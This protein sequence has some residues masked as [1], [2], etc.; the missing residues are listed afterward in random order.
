MPPHSNS[1]S[2][3]SGRRHGNESWRRSRWFLPLIGAVVLVL[4]IL[5]T[6]RTLLLNISDPHYGTNG[7]Y[8]NSKSVEEQTKHIKMLLSETTA[9]LRDVMHSNITL[10]PAMRR[11]AA[12]LSTE[13]IGAQAE[14]KQLHRVVGAGEEKV[15]KCVAEKHQVIK[16]LQQ[17][18]QTS[19]GASSSSSSTGNSQSSTTVVGAQ[20]DGQPAS[21]APTPRWLVIGI[22]TIAR[23]HNEDYLLTSL[24]VGG[25]GGGRRVIEYVSVCVGGGVRIECVRVC[26]TMGIVCVRIYAEMIELAA[27]VCKLFV[28][29]PLSTK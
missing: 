4:L 22:P 23:A 11:D 17:C 14:M 27:D 1:S 3:G 18:Q 9:L 28:S 5:L 2:G 26:T 10:S 29:S 15:V 25:L 21:S 20:G 24:Q 12:R 7:I 13:R 8:D 6:H 19:P 16:E